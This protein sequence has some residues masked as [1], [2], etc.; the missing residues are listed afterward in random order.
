MLGDGGTE[1]EKE[2]ADVFVVCESTAFMY[3]ILLSRWMSVLQMMFNRKTF[4]CQIGCLAYGTFYNCQSV[5]DL[6]ITSH[7]Q[8]KKKPQK[9]RAITMET[10]AVW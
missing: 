3:L 8:S 2:G 1:K 4:A 5:L 6:L 10:T 7:V 9:T